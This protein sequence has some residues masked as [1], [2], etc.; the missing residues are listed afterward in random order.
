MTLDLKNVNLNAMIIC[1]F[2][3]IFGCKNRGKL[4]SIF[5]N[6]IKGFLLS[7]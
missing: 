5:A 6:I 3:L 4:S 7:C 2:K 1:P